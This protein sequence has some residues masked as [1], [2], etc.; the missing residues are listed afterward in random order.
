M[1]STISNSPCSPTRFPSAARPNFIGH[2][3]LENVQKSGIRDRSRKNEG[4]DEKL[5]KVTETGCWKIMLVEI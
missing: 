4:Y 5:G 2:A 3:S 1:N